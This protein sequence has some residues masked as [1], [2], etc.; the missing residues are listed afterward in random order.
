MHASYNYML[1]FSALLVRRCRISCGLTCRLCVAAKKLPRGPRD[2]YQVAA[3]FHLNLTAGHSKRA[4][5]RPPLFWLALLSSRVRVRLP[6]RRRV[7]IGKAAPPKWVA[8]RRLLICP[9]HFNS[10]RRQQRSGCLSMMARRRRCHR[11]QV[12]EASYYRA[13][14]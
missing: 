14:R 10:Q 1:H 2:D 11:T 6:L 13:C 12:L 8:R 9:L 5:R 3:H 7:P 4:L